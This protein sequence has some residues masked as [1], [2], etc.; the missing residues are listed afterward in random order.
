VNELRQGI[1]G[2]TKGNKVQSTEI[3]IRQHIK[4]PFRP[5]GY[6][7][8]ISSCLCIFPILGSLAL[9]SILIRN[10]IS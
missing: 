9:S 3:R 5:N 6:D 2:N 7:S 10:D 1:R 8:T 4:T